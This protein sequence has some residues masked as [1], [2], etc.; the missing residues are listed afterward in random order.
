MLGGRM[1]LVVIAEALVLAMSAVSNAT[2]PTSVS[3]CSWSPGVG[4]M[5]LWPETHGMDHNHWMHILII[6]ISSLHYI[7]LKHDKHPESRDYL[8]LPSPSKPCLCWSQGQSFQKSQGQCGNCME[9]KM[10]AANRECFAKV[11]SNTVGIGP[12][13]VPGRILHTSDLKQV[14]TVRS[15]VVIVGMVGVFRNYP[16]MEKNLD[17]GTKPSVGIFP[18]SAAWLPSMPAHII[19]KCSL[20]AKAK[21]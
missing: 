7:Y 15:V 2:A 6:S 10:P 20:L 1:Q 9:L 3:R 17:W 19:P 5:P 14:T 13:Q 18:N 21:E 4:S 11:C 8:A 12:A 16:K